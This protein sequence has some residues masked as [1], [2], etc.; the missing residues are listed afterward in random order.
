VIRIPWQR[1]KHKRD[2]FKL[3]MTDFVRDLLL[4][5]GTYSEGGYVFPANSGSGHISEPKYPL[6]LV[7]KATDIEVSIHDL[8][9][10]YTTAAENT[11]MSAFALKALVDHTLPGNEGDVTAGYINMTVARLREPAQRVANLLKLWC[12][13]EN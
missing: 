6:G 1:T 10:D 11:D 3:P 4:K 5:I 12:G 8:R 7:A 2:V 13:L 9:R